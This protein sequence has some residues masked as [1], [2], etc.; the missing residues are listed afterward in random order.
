LLRDSQDEAKKAQYL[1]T[2]WYD[3]STREAHRGELVAAYLDLFHNTQDEAKKAQYL[4][5]LWRDQPTREAHRA[6]LVAAYL[7]LF[8]YTQ[9]EVNK[10]EC[11]LQL[12]SDQNIRINHLQELIA[13]HIDLA[14]HAS[15]K[16]IRDWSFDVLNDNEAARQIFNEQYSEIFEAIQERMQSEVLQEEKL[17][18]YLRD[19]EI[20]QEEFQNFIIEY[21]AYLSNEDKAVLC[22]KY[23]TQFGEDNLRIQEL[24]FL[25][26][27][28]GGPRDGA[29]KV[30][31]DLLLKLKDPFVHHPSV[32]DIKLDTENAQAL[33]F[34]INPEIFNYLPVNQEALATL[35]DVYF[36]LGDDI[37]S[38]IKGILDNTDPGNF[39][40]DF[41]KYFV[42]PFSEESM[43]L[44]AIIQKY[45]KM[46]L[47][48]KEK[49]MKIMPDLLQCKQGKDQAIGDHYLVESEALP[50]AEL[51]NIADWLIRLQ[52]N[53]NP[54]I[55]DEY[56]AT[57]FNK[58]RAQMITLVS[59]MLKPDHIFRRH[60]TDFQTEKAQLLK[61]LLGSVVKFEKHID[62]SDRVALGQNLKLAL[63]I[64][65][66][67]SNEEKFFETLAQLCE[68][69]DIYL[70]ANKFGDQLS[71][72]SMEGLIQKLKANDVNERGDLLT[73]QN[74]MRDFVKSEN[75]MALLNNFDVEEGAK[76]RELMR[77]YVSNTWPVGLLNLMELAC[78]EKL[79]DAVNAILD[80]TKIDKDMPLTWAN[81][82]NMLTRELLGVKRQTINALVENIT[83]LSHAERPHD[84][85][86]VEGLLG[87]IVGLRQ[88]DKM[89][90]FDIW[91][92]TH[93]NTTSK[94]LQE[95]LDLFHEDFTANR[96]I[97][98]VKEMI[99]TSK[100]SITAPGTGE[101]II[102]DMIR[103]A[104]KE[105]L[106][107][108]EIAKRMSEDNIIDEVIIEDYVNDLLY[109]QTGAT[110][111]AV[112]LLLTKLGILNEVD[113]N[114]H[115]ISDNSIIL[116]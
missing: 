54:Y 100:L 109:N 31:A 46:G 17:E 69:Y 8:H 107:D 97:N 58:S 7:E 111:L 99:D 104:A 2:L 106:R 96:I 48:G 47:K 63:D 92:M 67:L 33:Y 36:I 32:L 9:D 116:D 34:T 75:F 19:G 81:L 64:L 113:E 35:E 50:F 37:D 84:I 105:Q 22:E 98:H 72:T 68:V 77:G 45:K 66:K 112:A 11:L 86:Y 5:W 25:Y 52:T 3:Q 13:R 1:S 95:T 56:L 39:G 76:L 42:A 21:W 57:S 28:D 18:N 103:V 30:Y 93:E 27:C 108:K 44:Q 26:A 90:N 23:A 29:V 15:H 78:E 40:A 85:S 94:S 16:F 60:L 24:L 115:Q 65:V 79:E 14:Q 87:S 59:H 73:F 49:L 101:N 20:Y 43:M 83:G 38:Q 71:T 82:K 91:H 10:A 12:W 6:E 61:A 110:H 88:A 74:Q 89:P 53:N 102:W 70:P 4:W 62:L 80:Q 55:T 114:N 41:K 51:K